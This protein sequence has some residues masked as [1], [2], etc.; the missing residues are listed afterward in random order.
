MKYEIRGRARAWGGPQGEDV[1]NFAFGLPPP[2]PLDSFS[3]PPSWRAGP[4]PLT[5]RLRGRV[6]VSGHRPQETRFRLR[7]PP[8][9]FAHSRLKVT[10]VGGRV[11]GSSEQ[12]PPRDTGP[13]PAPARLQDPGTRGWRLRRD[14]APGRRSE[15]G[16]EGAEPLERGPGGWRRGPPQGEQEGE[17]REGRRRPRAPGCGARAA[18]CGA[19]REPP[20]DARA[21]SRRGSHRGGRG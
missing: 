4:R 19:G 9:G 2:P 21:R 10:P 6:G 3:V 1:S 12:Q 18:G 13:A 5:A 7:D 8:T 11:H 16:K 14:R 15:D 17:G 20:G